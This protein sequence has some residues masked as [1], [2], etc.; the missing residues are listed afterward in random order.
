MADI[1]AGIAG[2][3]LTEFFCIM[4]VTRLC[5]IDKVFG[6]L[7]S[8]GSPAEREFCLVASIV[9]TIVGDDVHTAEQTG[10]M[11]VSL[12]GLFYCCFMVY[13]TWILFA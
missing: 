9:Q 3:L 8:S 4:Y 6:R 11:I 10:D 13:M 12:R 2:R 1:M 5:H 7:D